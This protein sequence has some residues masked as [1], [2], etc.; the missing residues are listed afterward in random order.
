MDNLIK[1][2]PKN[3]TLS[4]AFRKVTED[5][6]FIQNENIRLQEINN[7]LKQAIAALNKEPTNSL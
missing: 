2:P 1:K 3:L 7:Q 5:I 4:D 6:I